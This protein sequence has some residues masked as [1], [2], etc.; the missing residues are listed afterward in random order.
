MF[1]TLARQTLKAE[2]LHISYKNSPQP[3]VLNH[4]YQWKGLK[5]GNRT[6]AHHGIHNAL[7]V[8]KWEVSVPR[9]EQFLLIG[10]HWGRPPSHH[11]L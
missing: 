3:Q 1:Q 2:T 7:L 8:Y 11:R 9:K 4:S 10:K 5:E 6:G